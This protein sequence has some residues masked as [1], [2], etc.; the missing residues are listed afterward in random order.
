MLTLQ[1]HPALQRQHQIRSIRKEARIITAQI[2]DAVQA[3]LQRILMNIEF[4]GGRFQ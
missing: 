4:C 1:Q 3:V 2:P